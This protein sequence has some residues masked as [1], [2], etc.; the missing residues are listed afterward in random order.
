MQHLK[1]NNNDLSSLE[2]PS[3]LDDFLTLSDVRPSFS[4]RWNL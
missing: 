4:E 2:D 1:N 3:M